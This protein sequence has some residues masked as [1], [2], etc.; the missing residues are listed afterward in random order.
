MWMFLSLNVCHIITQNLRSKFDWNLAHIY[1]DIIM[2][3]KAHFLAI[4]I[5]KPILDTSF[6]MNSIR[7]I[8]TC[9]RRYL[10]K[11]LSSETQKTED[12]YQC[13]ISWDTTRLYLHATSGK[14]C[15]TLYFIVFDR[16]IRNLRTTSVIFCSRKDTS[17]FSLSLVGGKSSRNSFTLL[18]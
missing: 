10:I 17:S 12:S 6:E 16:V 14:T 11:R 18:S 8:E 2:V 4:N 15:S 3:N 9:F 7:E 5:L 13:H 1:V